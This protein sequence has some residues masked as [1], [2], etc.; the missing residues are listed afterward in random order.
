MVKTRKNLKNALIELLG[1]HKISEISIQ[2][3]TD[4]AHVTRGT[5][6]LHYEDK[7]DFISRTL[8]EIM[9]GFFDAVIVRAD[10]VNDKWQYGEN[11]NFRLFS[12]NKAFDYIEEN[13]KTFDVLLNK[14]ENDDFRAEFES[15]LS[16]LLTEFFDQSKTMLN[17]TD[18]SKFSTDALSDDILI[19]Y[20][21]SA[22]IGIIQLWLQGGMKYTARYMTK[23]VDQINDAIEAQFPVSG[24]FV[25]Q[26]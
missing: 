14:Y 10:Y 20:L 12:I 21:V 22:H 5:F 2:K 3:I 11:G 8:A 9:T 18:G 4:T 23:S 16:K 7:N 1:E 6:Y 25:S 19:A 15:K 17:S 13:A 24:F 26:L